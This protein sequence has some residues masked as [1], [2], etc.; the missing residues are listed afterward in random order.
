MI[1]ISISPCSIGD[2]CDQDMD[3]DGALNEKD[4][5]PTKPN[6]D[7]VDSDE[8]GLG[9]GCDNCPR[10]KNPDQTDENQNFIGDIC[11]QGDDDDGDG[12]VGKSA[13]DISYLT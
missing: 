1:T 10:D 4:N 9:D 11:E 2:M 8:D 12:F 13:S 5:C 3:G 7:Q 6:P